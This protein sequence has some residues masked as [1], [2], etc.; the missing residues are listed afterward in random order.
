MP[1]KLPRSTLIWPRGVRLSAYDQDMLLIDQ[2]RDRNYD[3]NDNLFQSWSH[4][5]IYLGVAI[6]SKN[7][8]VWDEESLRWI[9]DRI[10][11]DLEFDGNEVKHLRHTRRAGRPCNQEFIWKLDVR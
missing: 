6:Y 11:E 10:V 1:L 9:E 4:R 3:L 5:I 8:P 2:S 7:W